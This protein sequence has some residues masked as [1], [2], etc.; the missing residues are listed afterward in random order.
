MKG[1]KVK[2]KMSRQKKR[3]K[4]KEKNEIKLNRKE[5]EIKDK[6][7]VYTEERRGERK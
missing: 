6:E 2:I 3:D 4:A 1:Y 7:C 5:G